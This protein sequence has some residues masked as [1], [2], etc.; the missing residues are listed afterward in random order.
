MKV[1]R[2]YGPKLFSVLY[3]L[4]LL[5]SNSH[6]KFEV[7]TVSETGVSLTIKGFSGSCILLDRQGTDRDCFNGNTCVKNSAS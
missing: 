3:L 7:L 2:K 6:L 1:L 5:S 4:L